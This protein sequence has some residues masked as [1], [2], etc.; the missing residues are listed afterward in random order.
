M[1]A[2][3]IAIEIDGDAWQREFLRQWPAGS[4]AHLSYFDRIKRGP[5][6]PPSDAIRVEE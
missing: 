1:H 6:Y 3:A 4:D 2:E 5:A